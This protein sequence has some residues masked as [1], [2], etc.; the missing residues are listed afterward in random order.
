[1]D[2]PMHP[3]GFLAGIRILDLADEKA[4]FCTKLL[5]DMGAHVIK[6]EKPGGD[7]SR[8]IGPFCND[9]SPSPNSL[10][11]FYNNTNKFG[12]TLD[13]EHSEGQSI[14]RKLVR[15]SDVVVETFPPGYLKQIGLDYEVLNGVNSRI[16][17]VS[18]S[19]FGQRGPRRDYKP[20]DAVVSASG[21]QMH[22]C[23]SP[24]AAPLKAFGNQ[25]YFTGSL[26]A[27]TGILLALRNRA[28]TGRG[29]YLDI[30]LQAS[31][32]ATLEQVMVR[33]FSEGVIDHRRESHYWNDDFV[34][35]P[36]RDGFMHVTLFQKWPTLVEWLDTEEMA[37]DL[38]D[39]KWLDEDYRRKHIGHVIEVL[40][41]WT[42]THSA[43][44]IFKLAQ[45][46]RF[47]WAPVQSPQEILDSPQLNAR[48]FWVKREDSDC[49]KM[50]RYPGNPC[51]TANESD[52]PANPAPLPGEH[53]EMIYRQE[54]GLSGDELKRLY[55]RKV[56]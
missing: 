1:M 4:S 41:K 51:K 21:G 46:M 6:V 15:K 50:L 19:G 16:I 54:L 30:S 29:E 49:E 45:L 11:F 43:D 35:L 8:K 14:F 9:T 3:H 34:V 37:E 28:K 47:P 36:C 55:G 26:F 10:S 18:V 48:N 13:L 33:Y 17:L 25:S 27:A 2:S 20:C 12:I 32:T 39:E 7:S 44:E 53:N 24:S 40:K 31:V 38:M 56:I 22:S 5:A 52:F 23:G 42:S